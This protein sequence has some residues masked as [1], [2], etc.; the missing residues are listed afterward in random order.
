[1]SKHKELQI[2]NPTIRKPT[3][4]WAV[5]VVLMASLV[6]GCAGSSTPESEHDFAMASLDAMPIDMRSA[7]DRARQAYQL[8]AGNPDIF[9]QIP[10]YCGCSAMGH[11]SNYDCYV[12][13]ANGDGT[14]TYDPHALVCTLCV[15]ITH[16]TVRLLKQG[17]SLPEVRE[18]IDANYSK[19]GPGTGAWFR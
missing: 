2:I 15:D 18:Y 16:D 4:L 12:S 13:G 10:C 7:P 17:Q 6:A 19:Y 5:L 1:M 3:F 11:T 9:I 8:S 14:L